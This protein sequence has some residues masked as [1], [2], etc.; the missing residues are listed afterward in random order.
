[1]EK[2]NLPLIGTGSMLIGLTL[3]LIIYNDDNL[4][5]RVA[6]E[7]RDHLILTEGLS[8]SDYPMGKYIKAYKSEA[9]TPMVSV[10][11]WNF[12]LQLISL[13][14]S[15]VMKVSVSNFRLSNR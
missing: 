5:Y 9:F 8:I 2:K 1:M 11:G 3:S 6:E 15:V 7:Y 10:P 4:T 14:I 13:I 12:V